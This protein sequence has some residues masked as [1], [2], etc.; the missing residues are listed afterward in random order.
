MASVLNLGGEADPPAQTT[1]DGRSTTIPT[2]PPPPTGG[3]AGRPDYIPEQFWRAM[4]DD[5]TRGEPNLEAWG[6]AWGDTK[7]HATKLEQELAELRK[8]ANLPAAPQSVDEY[9]TGYDLAKL[10]EAAPKVIPEEDEAAGKGAR[11]FFTL[12]H[13]HGLSLE[14]A[15]GIFGDYMGVLNQALPDAVEHKV[16][17]E[18]RVKELGTEGATM[19]DQVDKAIESLHGQ[20]PF[21]EEQVAMLRGMVTQPG[22]IGVLWRVFKAGGSIA[23]PTAEARSAD[24]MTPY[25]IRQAMATPRYRPDEVYRKRIQDAHAAMVAERPAAEIGTHRSLSLG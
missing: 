24:R 3:P 16:L 13:K 21:S 8:S 4:A 19:V 23:P 18:Q 20:Q 14:Q 7:G 1:E 25:E 17:V 6:K 9:L 2:D 5:P 11:E 10:R 22:G 15:R 12:A